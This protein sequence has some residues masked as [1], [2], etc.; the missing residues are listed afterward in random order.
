VTREDRIPQIRQRVP[1]LDV[2]EEHGFVPVRRNGDTAYLHCPFPDHTDDQPSFTVKDLTWACWSQCD[3]R[4]DVIDLVMGL[5]G[6]PKATAIR[7]L[8]TKAGLAHSEPTPPRQRLSTDKA[9]ELLVQFVS[10]R[11]WDPVAVEEIPLRVVL[12]DFDRPR[13][14]FPY[15]YGEEIVWHQDR[16]IGNASPK[17]LSPKAK[18][19]AIFNANALKLPGDRDGELLV[20]E[21]P[22][23]VVA[24]LS[25]FEAPAVVGIPGS[26]NFR[27]EWVE[28]FAGLRQ[29]VVIG[30]NDRA[31]LQF[32]ER[33]GSHL[34]SVVGSVV[35]LYVPEPF[36]DL[37]DWRRWCGTSEPEQFEGPLL[38]A[39]LDAEIRLDAVA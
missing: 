28:V 14:R 25:T 9:K 27:P 11:Q 2:L 15:S 17:W 30:D 6:L 31:G 3:T 13:V 24:M 19:P 20:C 16:A 8:A 22:S 33:L 1:I 12:D 39:A 35:H 36:N 34:G 37:D 26:G 23:D 5:D 29:V 10:E 7:Q 4:G 21:G 38:Q 18:R 32:R